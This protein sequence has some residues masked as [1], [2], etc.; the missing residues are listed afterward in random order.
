MTKKECG[1]VPDIAIKSPCADLA[2][3][4]HKNICVSEAPHYTKLNLRGD[5]GDAPFTSV[6]ASTLG[7]T[8]PTTAMEV[9]T[10]DGWSISWLGPNEWQITGPADAALEDQTMKRL[11]EALDGTHFALTDVSDYYTTIKLIGPKAKAV[12]AKGTA[13]NMS[14]DRFAVGQCAMT[15]FEKA[16]I[17][18]SYT[19]VD[20][21]EVQVRWSM[22]P[23]L[24]QWLVDASSEYCVE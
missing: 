3:L 5:A 22:A 2:P 13:F 20:S 14:A 23:Y 17:L 24:F 15:L 16:T 10:N 12:L 18:L 9:A 11:T 7:L 21:F 6:I 8:V 1:L 19:A 4:D